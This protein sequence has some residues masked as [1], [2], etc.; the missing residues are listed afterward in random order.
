[1]CHF[2]P[3]LVSYLSH[4]SVLLPALNIVCLV[5]F[6]NS[7]KYEIRISV[8]VISIVVNS[9]MVMSFIQEFVRTAEWW[10]KVHWHKHFLVLQLLN[11][12]LIFRGV[13]RWK[14]NYHWYNITE[15]LFR[16]FMNQFDID[17][18]LFG[19]QKKKKT[20]KKGASEW[21]H[22]SSILSTL[23]LLFNWYLFQVLNPTEISECIPFSQGNSSMPCIR[24][25]CF[26]YWFKKMR[27]KTIIFHMIWAKKKKRKR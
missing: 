13:G 18:F 23:C 20:E 16:I 8:L 1:M 4:C 10:E 14:T 6:S 26:C 27:K 2:M 12:L 19:C 5:N 24:I 9:Y 3:Y 25:K 17:L 22:R 21:P 7:S 15:R 11:F